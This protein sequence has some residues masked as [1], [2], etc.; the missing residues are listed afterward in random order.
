MLIGLCTNP[1]SKQF[2]TNLQDTPNPPQTW[3]SSIKPSVTCIS[4]RTSTQALER[5]LAWDTP[6]SPE[7]KLRV[8]AACKWKFSVRPTG[9]LL[10]LQKGSSEYLLPANESSLS[11]LLGYLKVVN[12]EGGGWAVWAAN[13]R[14]DSYFTCSSASTYMGHDHNHAFCRKSSE[15]SGTTGWQGGWRWR[16]QQPQKVFRKKTQFKASWICISPIA[17]WERS[18]KSWRNWKLQLG[19]TW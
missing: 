7:R 15:E 12:Y 4:A 19:M 10:A 18:K 16:S 2:S 8:A 6:G 17:F 1:R 3:T 5:F 14:S 13:M 9:T 11:R